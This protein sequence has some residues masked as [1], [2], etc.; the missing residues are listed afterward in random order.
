VPERSRPDPYFD[1]FTAL[2]GAR[3]LMTAVLLGVFDALHE[4]PATAA[5][6]AVRLGLDPLC[7]VIGDSARPEPGEQASQHGA[8]SSILFYACSHSR[9]FKPSEIHA[10]MH[11][12]RFDDVT[13][14]RNPLSPWR[15]VVVG[16]NRHRHARGL[17]RQGRLEGSRRSRSLYPQM[18]DQSAGDAARPGHLVPRATSWYSRRTM[19]S[20]LRVQ[21]RVFFSAVRP[22]GGRNGRRKTGRPSRSSRSPALR[23]ANPTNAAIAYSPSNPAICEACSFSTTREP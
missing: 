22:T 10:W 1:S 3:A 4:Q 19:R 21:Q 13:V 5:E 14:H 18:A 9:N 11:E 16:R 8:I 20:T 15:V 7:L 17:Y 23:A 12:T 2:V 6:L